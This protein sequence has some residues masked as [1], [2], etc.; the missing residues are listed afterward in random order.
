[1]KV[2]VCVCVC[3]LEMCRQVR[4]K[5][6]SSERLI[7]EAMERWRKWRVEKE[8]RVGREEKRFS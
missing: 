8:S 2:C 3:V 5:R 7:V 6:R 4:Q 1:M